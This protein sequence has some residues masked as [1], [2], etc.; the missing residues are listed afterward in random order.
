MEMLQSPESAGRPENAPVFSLQVAPD[1]LSAY[2]KVEQNGESGAVE[3]DDAANFLKEQGIVFGWMEDALRAYCAKGEF[4]TPLL[5]AQGQPPLDGTDGSLSYFFHTDCTLRPKEREDG[6][7][8]FR[9]LGLV[10]NVKKGSLLCRIVPPGPGEDGT[11]VFGRALPCI[12]GRMPV[13]PVGGNTEVSADGLELYA[14]RDGCIEFLKSAVNINEVY[15]VRGEVGIAS[16]NLDVDGSVIVQGDVRSGFSVKA[17]GDISVRGMV[18]GASLEAGGSIAISQGMNGM[19]LGV[20][21]AG[22]NISGKYFEHAALTAGGNIFAE[23]MLN[24]RAGA[25][26]SIELKGN[27]AAF[28]GGEYLA[29]VKIKGKDIGAPGGTATKAEIQS[30]ALAEVLALGGGTDRLDAVRQ[31][32]AA[33]EQ[34]LSDYVQNYDILTAQ[35]AAIAAGAPERGG[36]LKKAAVQKRERLSER[37]QTLKEQTA[38]LERQEA[39]LLHYCI[40]IRGTAFAGVR[41]TVGPYHFNLKNNYSGTRFYISQNEMTAGP[42]LST[43]VP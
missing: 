37:A 33:A 10:Q 16:G 36:L 8:D 25:A 31:K 32:L 40:V 14:A 18:E 27:R 19:G 12:P 34:E 39:E 11:D 5:C 38:A 30:K 35:I 43:D 2:L 23:V 26:G 21:K 3:Y 9:E 22:G 20:L 15:L 4:G 1:N 17:S 42:I 13:L 28:I 7:V 29:G 6:T 41:L 24:C